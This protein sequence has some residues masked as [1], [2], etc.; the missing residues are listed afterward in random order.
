MANIPYLNRQ[1]LNPFRRPV[2][3][4]LNYMHFPN[5]RFLQCDICNRNYTNEGTEEALIHYSRRLFV[6]YLLL[7]YDT[8][9]LFVSS[10][11]VLKAS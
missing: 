7:A 6:N 2:Q 10:L 8:N 4:S 5:R 11:V 9:I 3:C 1:S